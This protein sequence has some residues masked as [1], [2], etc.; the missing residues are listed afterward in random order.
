MDLDPKGANSQI[1][2]ALDPTLNRAGQEEA[3]SSTTPSVTVPPTSTSII[4]AAASVDG[5]LMIDV[6]QPIIAPGA[7]S[8]QSNMVTEQ[9]AGTNSMQQPALNI[10]VT[11]DEAIARSR[12]I[13]NLEESEDQE[14]L[15]EPRNR[16]HIGDESA[17]TNYVG[18]ATQDGNI[19]NVANEEEITSPASE[20]YRESGN[21]RTRRDRRHY[22]QHPR[23]IGID[24]NI[25][26]DNTETQ[27]TNDST[28]EG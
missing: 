15:M 1:K 14:D 20:V 9:D 10:E 5:S 28:M 12:G 22:R 19:L 7:N 25:A 23:H 18:S 11:G 13:G 2:D 21:Q 16:G 24:I 3:S 26:D 27:E 8:A 4:T 6:A 17:G